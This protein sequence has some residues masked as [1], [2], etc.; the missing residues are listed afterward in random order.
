V[1]QKSNTSS[2]LIEEIKFLTYKEFFNLFKVTF[3]FTVYYGLLSAIKN[4]WKISATG[5]QKET[6]KENWYDNE[7]NLSNAA[8]HKIIVENKFQPTTNENRIISYGVE[9]SEIQKLYKWPFC[10]TENT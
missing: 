7:D 9:T 10:V 1:L 3:S 4:K 6:R 2:T 8:L 5:R